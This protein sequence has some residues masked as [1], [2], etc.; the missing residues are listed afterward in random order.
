MSSEINMKPEEISD[1]PKIIVPAEMTDLQRNRLR[2]MS[3]EYNR[4]PSPPRFPRANL[5]LDLDRVKNKQKVLESEYNIITGSPMSTDSDITPFRENDMLDVVDH[6]DVYKFKKFGIP[7]TALLNEPTP[8]SALNTAGLI[9]K[10]GFKF[11][12][13]NNVDDSNSVS[14]NI[15]T[16]KTN[17]FLTM[18]MMDTDEDDIKKSSTKGISLSEF[19][20]IKMITF[21]KRLQASIVIPLSTQLQILNN[22]IFKIFLCDLKIINHFRSLRHFYFLM[23]GEFGSSICD[24]L[25]SRLEQGSNPKE[26]FYFNT[27]SMILE[28]ALGTSAL[29]DDSNADRLSFNV[30][31]IPDK[32]DLTAPDA[33]GDLSLCYQVKWPLNLIINSEVLDHYA[34]IFRYLIKVRRMS[35]ILEESMNHLKSLVKTQGRQ[36]G[37]APQYLYIQQFRHKL[38]H[39]I[40]TLQNYITSNALQ[41][42]WKQFKDQLLTTTTIEGLYHSHITYIKQ[43]L[44]LCMLNRQSGKY[45]KAIEGIFKI[46]IKFYRRLIS[47]KW[48]KVSGNLNFTHSKYDKLL[49]D[50]EEFDASV[51]YIVHL[52]QKC[53]SSGYQSEIFQFI[54]LINLNG[55]YNRN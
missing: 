41:A 45:Y 12:V 34:T 1:I 8:D 22:E 6:K 40:M 5:N 9:A 3:E 15:A 53:A 52:G 37:M 10:D 17:L 11:P 4:S 54:T 26:L 23:D 50:A 21:T 46:T 48:R 24:G 13:P 30:N 14:S 55:Y 47:G 49:K 19:S 51:K 35:W 25:I 32:F 18:M 44:F 29:C 33:F 20:D 38:T 28:N 16:K 7:D 43:I 27:L 2:V 36:L 42:T 39:F 31:S